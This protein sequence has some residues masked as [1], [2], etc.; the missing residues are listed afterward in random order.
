M[1]RGRGPIRHCGVVAAGGGG[2]GRSG[3]IEVSQRVGGGVGGR[4]PCRSGRVHRVTMMRVAGVSGGVRRVGM[5]VSVVV[6]SVVAMQSATHILY[7][8]FISVNP[9]IKWLLT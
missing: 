2:G 8:K 6:A 3:A 5:V 4:V 9:E 1:P 7:L